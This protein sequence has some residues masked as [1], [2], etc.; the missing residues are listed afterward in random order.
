MVQKLVD[1]VRS[2]VEDM[3]AGLEKGESFIKIANRISSKFFDLEK[4]SGNKELTTIMFLWKA[5]IM[6]LMAIAERIVT[7]SFP[8]EIEKCTKE[9]DH[10]LARSFLRFLVR[11]NLK[12]ILYARLINYESGE[13]SFER[14]RREFDEIEQAQLPEEERGFIILMI[15][16]ALERGWRR[17]CEEINDLVKE[18]VEELDEKLKT[19]E[20]DG[21]ALNVLRIV[22]EDMLYMLHRNALGG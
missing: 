13:V 3:K 14:I 2:V 6:P 17:A 4:K 21:K 1:E 12:G 7:R 5:S 19:V 9:E 15:A 22:T 16:E 20:D 8:E 10:K 11:K 18:Y